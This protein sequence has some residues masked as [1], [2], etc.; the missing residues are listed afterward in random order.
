MDFRSRAFDVLAA[1]DALSDDQSG[2]ENGVIAVRFDSVRDNGGFWRPFLDD[3][4]HLI[5]FQV[6]RSGTVIVDHPLVVP[7][8][9]SP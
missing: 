3:S 1:S 6:L 8:S 7:A 9:V 2:D 5:I 4:L